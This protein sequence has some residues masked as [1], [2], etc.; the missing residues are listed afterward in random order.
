MA[1][2]S[3]DQTIKLWRVS[4]GALLQTLEGHRG[5]VM[6]VAFTP[7]G[8][9]V[10]SGGGNGVLTGYDSASGRKRHA[11]IGHTGT[12]WAVAPSPDGRTLLSGSAEARSVNGVPVERIWFTVNGAEPTAQRGLQPVR[13]HQDQRALLETTIGLEPGLNTVAI[14]AKNRHSQSLPE[15]VQITR[16]AA[17]LEKPN[18]YLLAIGVSEYAERSQNLTYAD[19]D[20]TAIAR[21]FTQQQGKLYRRMESRLLTNADANREAILDGLDWLLKSATQRDVAVIFIAGHGLKD[22]RNNYYFIPHDGDADNLRRTGVKWFDFQ[23]TLSGLPG[24]RI[25]LAD[26]CH[27]GGITGKRRS[28]ASQSDLTDAIRD[29][30]Q[31]DGGVVVMAASTEGEVSIEHRDWGHGAFTKALIEGLGEYRADYSQD[32]RIDIKELDLWVTE[33]VKSLTAG[34]Q[35]PTTEIPTIVPNFPLGLS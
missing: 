8:A 12:V 27:S 26:T 21:T 10:I 31:A 17:A 11:F 4:D 25:L 29:L 5:E 16:S 33:R 6:A 3:D 20:A 28:G 2:G 1:T 34:K 15:I 32:G 35:H 19:D 13:S 18:L 9:T 14:F 23:D 30:R 7:D 24:T 22:E